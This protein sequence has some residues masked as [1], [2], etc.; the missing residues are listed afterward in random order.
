MK[1]VSLEEFQKLVGLSDKALIWLLTRNLVQC[2]IVAERGLCVDLE[3]VDTKS[4]R[5]SILARR[6]AVLDRRNEIIVERL[7]NVVRDELESIVDEA[8]GHYLAEEKSE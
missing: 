7:G 3:S 2:Q 8:I 1:I 4:L 5:E 6:E